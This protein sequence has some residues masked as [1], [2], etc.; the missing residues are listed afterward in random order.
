MRPATTVK[1]LEPLATAL[2][3]KREREGA[4]EDILAE[5]LHEIKPHVSVDEAHAALRKVT[6]WMSHKS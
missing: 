5:R 1:Q 4:S 2:F 3:L 6:G